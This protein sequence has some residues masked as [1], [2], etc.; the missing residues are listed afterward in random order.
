MGERG[1]RA[2]LED[3]DHRRYANPR[4]VLEELAAKM[5][6]VPEELGPLWFGVAGSCQRL[7]F[8]YQ[9]ARECFEEGMAL[10]NARL[11]HSAAGDLHQR[12][13]TL[14][15]A[16]PNYEK[17]FAETGFAMARYADAHDEIGMAKVL[18]DRG[19]VLGNMGKWKWS[20]QCLLQALRVLP[21]KVAASRA[22][23]LLGRSRN[24]M[25]EGKGNAALIT[26]M[27]AEETARD[28][29]NQAKGKWQ[30]GKILVELGRYPEGAARIEQA[31]EALMDLAPN[32]GVLATL[33]LAG[34][35]LAAGDSESAYRMARN[36]GAIL[37]AIE[38]GAARLAAVEL[39]NLGWAGRGLSLT[40]LQNARERLR[41]LY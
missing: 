36:L 22:A 21:Q 10:A 31:A 26:A 6:E 40:V 41:R 9:R 14:W 30:T 2:W 23:A 29:L 27:E 19:L 33:D 39:V 4:A 28:P 1:M 16:T 37:P 3:C 5:N 11:D 34:I 32:N 17:A 18:V 24:L 38:R 8:R 12:I 25:V 35:Y 20:D 15:W 13:F 7:L